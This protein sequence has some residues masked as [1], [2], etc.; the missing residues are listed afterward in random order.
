M[1]ITENRGLV[2]HFPTINEIGSLE[3]REV[4][5]ESTTDKIQCLPCCCLIAGG[6]LITGG[7]MFG[8]GK[9]ACMD[10][11]RECPETLRDTGKYMLIAGGSLMG[12][13][14]AA[15]AIPIIC[16]AAVACCL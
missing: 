16:V 3:G 6:L 9:S 8:V 2:V 10:P 15:V 5:D 14:C 1:S 7:I 13:A 12:S 11:Q 4:Q